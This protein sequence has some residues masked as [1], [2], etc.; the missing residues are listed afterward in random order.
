MLKL[1]VIGEEGKR[2]YVLI[3][4]FNTTIYGHALDHGRKFFCHFYLQAFSGKE[5]LNS[6][7]KDYFKINGKQRIIMLEKGTFVKFKNYKRKIK[8][9]VII[10]AVKYLSQ[11]FDKE[12]SHVVKQKG[13]YPYEYTTDFE[14]FKEKLPSKDRFYNSLTSKKLMTKILNMLLMF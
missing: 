14:K 1:L 3:K 8:S 9:P 6:H 4:D 2:N 13:F 12:K 11:E 7:M 5:L 10:Y